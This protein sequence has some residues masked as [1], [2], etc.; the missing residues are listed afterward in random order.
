MYNVYNYYNI[1]L[2]SYKKEGVHVEIS[3]SGKMV[4]SFLQEKKN[5]KRRLAIFL[6]LALVVSLVTTA[7]LKLTGIAKTEEQTLLN[8]P[9]VIHEHAD[10]CYDI[11][12]NLACG[13]ADFVVHTHSLD[14]Y[15]DDVLA[16][17]LSEIEAHAH[18]ENCYTSEK[19]LICD[20]SE[21][22]S[23]EAV[24]DEAAADE[25]VSDESA[26]VE[27][28]S[29]D[30][31]D[32]AVS[33]ET[34]P[35]E[36]A[37]DEEA[38]NEAV[39]DDAVSDES[40][41]DN[42]VSD[43]I[44]F[45]DT[46]SNETAL[47]HVHTDECYE[48]R[49][50]LICEKEEIILHTHTTEC[51][52]EA[53]FDESGVMVALTSQLPEDATILDTWTRDLVPACGQLQIEEH[54]H[55]PGCLVPAKL[56]PEE[57]EAY[58][59]EIGDDGDKTNPNDDDSNDNSWSGTI[60]CGDRKDIGNGTKTV[61]EQFTWS[62]TINFPDDEN[63]TD[64][65]FAN[66]FRQ[67][68]TGWILQENGEKTL[69]EDH[70]VHH[71]QSL[72]NLEKELT[73]ALNL[74]L[75]QAGLE[76]SI[77][78]TFVYKDKAG[79]EVAKDNAEVA[80][81]EIY[82]LR[83][84]GRN[85]S[86]QSISFEYTSLV[87]TKNFVD[88]TNY[89]INND[90]T[91]A[92]FAGTGSFNFHYTNNI[93]NE[94]ETGDVGVMTV[95]L[96]AKG[97]PLDEDLPEQMEMILKQ[98]ALEGGICLTEKP[99]DAKSWCALTLNLIQ[100]DDVEP[101][102][103]QI[104]T[105]SDK[106]LGNNSVTVWIP[107]NAKVELTSDHY[108][109]TWIYDFKVGTISSYTLNLGVEPE[110]NNV[111]LNVSGK[112]PAGFEP[113][114]SFVQYSKITLNGVDD[115]WSYT[116]EQLPLNDG[117]NTQYIY[118]VS[119][120]EAPDG[121]D[122]TVEDDGEGNFT[123]TNQRNLELGTITVEM[124][125]IDEDGYPM[126]I[127][128]DSVNVYLQKK[129]YNID[130]EDGSVNYEWVMVDGKRKTLPNENGEWTATWTNLDEGE[131]RVVEEMVE[132]FVVSYFYTYYDEDGNE[133]SNFENLPGNSGFVVITNTES[134]SG[135]G[136]IV[137]IKI[138]EYEDGTPD[139]DH[140]DSVL[141]TVKRARRS[142]TEEDT[143]NPDTSEPTTNPGTTEPTT[144]SSTTEPTTNPSTTEPT[145]NPST[146][147]STTNPS[148]TEPSTNPGTTEPTTNP[149]TTEPSTSDT[150]TTKPSTSEKDTTKP[151]ISWPGTPYTGD[152]SNLPLYII[153]ALVSGTLLIGLTVYGVKQR[154]RKKE[155][156]IEEDIDE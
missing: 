44:V 40:A 2:I 94:T 21:T 130:P 18:D 11:G 43:E 109:P 20:L 114:G 146:T 3:V 75:A 95:W 79:N 47:S 140:P 33:D 88:N 53:V 122:T 80:Y 45:D 129:V 116:W 64:F 81:F 28:I 63:W 39:A 27:A 16:C 150:G 142:S 147:E 135:S 127:H 128:P 108:D 144:N 35:D 104:K 106:P 61:Q 71:Y 148:T 67:T 139:T 152:H 82:F 117:N 125:W 76:K 124:E 74:S 50:T 52:K 91:L 86:G 41:S 131:Y 138:W 10:N 121:Y 55:G 132:G 136:D 145:T 155:K 29:D 134:L 113:S 24:G 51:F 84:A 19:Y 34:A 118:T 87:D 46:V 151:G 17:E 107:K 26:S 85:L 37:P 31:A 98:Y 143:T 12:G 49:E 73:D 92:D 54:I 78:Y 120:A 133:Y 111:F 154:N 62:V 25:T 115:D 15:Y 97:D 96:D 110:I 101:H 153:I 156:E 137:V 56:T 77:S 48:A 4:E 14:C 100:D 7:A 93:S 6:C 66:S 8:C 99:A 105:L 126:V 69:E 60:E 13:Y 57:E 38:S 123:V 65:T 59:K 9:V 32:D 42:G 90:F 30:T 89:N 141:V 149:S 1:L 72:A 23:D 102:D 103:V 70:A 36:S 112:A 22:V 119:E 5:K 68:V 83:E 58:I